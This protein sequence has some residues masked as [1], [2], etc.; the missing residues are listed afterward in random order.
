MNKLLS[1]LLL[2]TGLCFIALASA[3]ADNEDSD[4]TTLSITREA[5]TAKI[6][7]A[8]SS[9]DLTDAARA[10]L[11]ELYRLAISN[12]EELEFNRARIKT[13]QEA[14]RT[15]RT[16]AQLER[17]ELAKLDAADPTEKMRV[18][19][20]TALEE[21]VPKLEK[22]RADQAAV[23]ARLMDLER[24]LVN[25]TNRPALISQQLAETTQKQ[26][27]IAAA[28]QAPTD[29]DTNVTLVQ[30][31]R[32][33][34][35]SQHAMYS[36]K[37][38]MLDQEL[39]S[40]P[41]RLDLLKAK[42]DK[43][44]A[45]VAW[46]DARVKLLSELINR[47]RQNEAEASM[48]IAEQTLRET[49]GLDPVL[50]E[51]AERNT[52]LTNEFATMA[53]QLDTLDQE[54]TQASV[55][56][57][58][59]EADFKDAEAT[60]EAK[61][62]P[63]GLGQL[64]LKH[65]LTLPNPKTYTVRTRTHQKQIA[66]IGV[67]RLH[68][69]EE[70]RR[71]S[72]LDT[73]VTQLAAKVNTEKTPEL[74][75]KI[76]ALVTQR[77]DLLNKALEDKE[78]YLKKLRELETAE[79]KLLDAVDAYDALLNEHLFWLRTADPIHLT[80]IAELPDEILDLFSPTIWSELIT[81]FID[82]GS[83]SI[84]FW[85]ALIS[86]IVLLSK[87]RSLIAAIE[88]TAIPVGK[89][90]NDSFIFT[91][92]A[93]IL[94]CIAAAPLPSLLAAIGLTLPDS[95]IG[96]RLSQS[97]LTLAMY[98][99][100]M[101]LLRIISIPQGLAVAHFR[102]PTA[103]AKILQVEI[104]RLAWVFVPTGIVVLFAIDAKPE[105]MGGVFA[106][107]GILVFGLSISLFFYRVFKST[108]QQTKRIITRRYLYRLFLLCSLP[109][110]A[111]ALVL[112]GYIYSA[113]TLSSMMLNTFWALAILML[114]HALAQRWLTIA[115]RRLAYK[116]ALERR[117]T[118]ITAR[119]AEHADNSAEID[120]FE[121]DEPELDLAELD[122]KSRELVKITVVTAAFIL[123]YV[124]WS[125]LLPAFRVLDNIT[126]W[127]YNTTVAGEIQS[128]PITLGSIGLALIYA[129]GTYVLVKKLPSVLNLIL[130]QRSDISSSSRYTITTLSTYI[131]IAVGVLLTLST[132]GA[133]WSQL[134][135][136]IA[137]LGVGIGFGLQEIVANFIS[138][139]IILFERPIRVGDIV[140]LGDTDGIVT[141]IRIRATTVRNWDRKELLIPNKDLITGR[142]INWSLSDSISRVLIPVGVAYG[143]DVAKALALMH[144]AAEE[145][146]RVL[147]DPAPLLTFEGFGDN[148]L[149][150][151]LR[152]YIGS[153]DYRLKTITELHTAINQ[154]FT[155]AGISIA[156]PQRDIH[157][158][159]TQPLNIR[160]ENTTAT[161]SGKQ[162]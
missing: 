49:A 51:F 89:V 23:S 143:S 93:L 141:K 74:L 56:A 109:V 150:L 16:Q 147:E 98:F 47:K 73:A 76:R 58:R 101:Q 3:L 106:K 82:E 22:E 149:T 87:R 157:L 79:R 67:Q 44:A 71:I 4:I 59:I 40:Y 91:L 10:E 121:V 133:Q 39:L 83:Q 115:Q 114:A 142:V 28:L 110:A 95:D 35:E 1:N 9:S 2:I 130:L 117:Q 60:L 25:E 11:I 21:L 63:V 62:K 14:V 32:W 107:L 46:I 92:R 84:L 85:L 140:T 154:K 105:E 20:D 136:L 139:L 78:F 148:A 17:D 7:L 131:I 159:T 12:L 99:Y 13:F 100:L 124:I 5:L 97:Y 88:R 55:L 132:I 104:Q 64:L 43:A 153:L 66:E 103:N 151:I 6:K 18:T 61:R 118:M 45:S 160:I 112:T 155:D 162:E 31:K 50:M 57:R 134:Q 96:A 120:A 65:R 30:A 122:H 111:I 26:K 75:D 37:I 86:I 36:A 27:E 161:E 116:N 119:E 42:R 29:A 15:A 135:W 94:S 144:E 8:E 128:H 53:A 156:F 127:Y 41:M 158:D 72:D 81:G 125:P 80:N 52:A 54:K 69:R 24:R 138:G 145:N 108:Q 113:A 48:L 70:L 77:Q 33:A 123:L 19:D 34:L 129:I 38:K 90:N 152:A 68:H 146:E 137:A 102:W 126:L